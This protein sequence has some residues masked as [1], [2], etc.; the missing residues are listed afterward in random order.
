ML[1]LDESPSEWRASYVRSHAV[2]ATAMSSSAAAARRVCELEFKCEA[3][4]VPR[5]RQ[6]PVPIVETS[7]G[8]Y[9]LRGL[10]SDRHI[11]QSAGARG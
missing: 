8:L 2:A 11:R 5:L 7:A 3:I 1:L 4:S 10:G 6:L 9:A